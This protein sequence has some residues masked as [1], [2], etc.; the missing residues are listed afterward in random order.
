MNRLVLNGIF[1]I[2]FQPGL[3]FHSSD[4]MT[5]CFINPFTPGPSAAI[6]ETESRDQIDI[7]SLANEIE[8]HRMPPLP[9]LDLKRR[10]AADSLKFALNVFRSIKPIF[11]WFSTS[12]GSP[13]KS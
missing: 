3:F 11:V 9:L 5:H 6:V 12:I 10:R 4:S 2:K 7:D 13:F 8:F 1:S